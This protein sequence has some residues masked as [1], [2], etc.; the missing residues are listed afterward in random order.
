MVLR[1]ARVPRLLRGRWPVLVARD[2]VVW[3]PGIGV[4]A[5][6]ADDGRRAPE[7]AIA[8]MPIDGSHAGRPAA[9]AGHPDD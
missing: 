1:D 8:L 7:A 2:R 6:V 5:A 4:D 3:V 9:G